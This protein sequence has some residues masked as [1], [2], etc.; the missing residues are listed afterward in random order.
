MESDLS[1]TEDAFSV[2]ASSVRL[3]ILRTLRDSADGSP[4]SFTELYNAVDVAST[5]QFS[6]HLHELTDRYVDHTDDGYVISDTGRRVV[7]SVNAD[8]YTL[9]PE[10]EPV[11]VSTYCPYCAETDAEAT[12]DGQLAAV[13]CR[14]CG[15][16][17]LRYDLR[18]AHVADRNSLEALK[19]ADRQMRAEYGSALVGV[20]QR[21]GGSIETELVTGEDADPATAIL[22]CDCR[23]CGTLISAPVSI[24]ILHHPDVIS[25]CL[26]ETVDTMATPIW[27]LFELVSAWDVV[28]DGP[29]DVAVVRTEIRHI[30]IDARADLVIRVRDTPAEDLAYTDR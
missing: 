17:L 6:Y 19:A 9:Q 26:N 25:K 27:Q 7:R 12:Y 22:V 18:P 10:F 21:C 28:L 29:N 30:R 2:L 4:S 16:T 14:S 5:S 15:F 23:Y 20:C 11:D 8:E 1:D 3:E 24:A 13:D